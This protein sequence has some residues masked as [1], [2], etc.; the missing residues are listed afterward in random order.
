METLQCRG[1]SRLPVFVYMLLITI[2][3]A[4]H[5]WKNVSVGKENCRALFV[6]VAAEQ[7]QK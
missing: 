5:A 4:V 2:R 1:K 6:L 7:V 3:G